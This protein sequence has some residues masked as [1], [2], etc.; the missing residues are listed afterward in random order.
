MEIKK[1]EH[2]IH[3]VPWFRSFFIKCMFRMSDHL[4]ENIQTDGSRVREAESRRQTESF[5]LMFVYC[6][7][8]RIIRNRIKRQKKHYQSTFNHN[9]CIKICQCQI[10]FRKD[11]NTKETMC[12]EGNYTFF[13]MLISTVEKR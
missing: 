13:F 7:R 8:P 6:P 5:Y 1:N 4:K 2:I 11:S 9:L 3:V 10:S 12:K